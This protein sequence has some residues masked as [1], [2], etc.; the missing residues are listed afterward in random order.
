MIQPSQ[1]KKLKIIKYN[2]LAV[3]L[4]NFTRILKHLIYP[5]F[6]YYN[7]FIQVNTSLKANYCNVSFTR[8]VQLKWMIPGIKNPLNIKPVNKLSYRS[9]IVT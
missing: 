6:F 2:V 4:E 8:G 7:N 1:L 5:V 3:K 9:L